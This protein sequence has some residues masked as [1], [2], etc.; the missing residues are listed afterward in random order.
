MLSFLIEEHYWESQRFV[1]KMSA[2]GVVCTVPKIIT[3]SAEKPSLSRLEQMQLLNA[4][5]LFPYIWPRNQ[6][7]IV[8]SDPAV[9]GSVLMRRFRLFLG[10]WR[11]VLHGKICIVQQFF[12]FHIFICCV[13]AV[14]FYLSWDS[15]HCTLKPAAH[16]MWHVSYIC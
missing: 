9:T 12:Y 7:N 11:T 6:T 13:W 3:N 16:L 2:R 10:Q 15:Q 1:I 5:H 14:G 4:Q 8:A